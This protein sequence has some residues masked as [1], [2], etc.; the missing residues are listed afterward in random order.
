MSERTRYIADTDVGDD[1]FDILNKAA[2]VLIN[3]V[4]YPVLGYD[5]SDDVLCAEDHTSDQDWVIT[6][7]SEHFNWLEVKV[8]VSVTESRKNL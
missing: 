2:F 7:A 8:A 5:E 3:R 1:I 4:W 6:K